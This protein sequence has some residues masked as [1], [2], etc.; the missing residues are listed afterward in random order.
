MTKVLK[1]MGLIIAILLEWF[2]ILTIMVVFAIRSSAFQTF[3]ARQLTNYLSTELNTKVEIGGVDIVLFK[4]VDLRNFYMEDRTK[5]PLLHLNHLFIELDQF[6]YNPNKLNIKHLRLN[7]GEIN[8][9]REQKNGNYNYAFIQHYIDANYRTK[10]SKQFTVYLNEFSLENIDL[11]YNDFRRESIVKG[12]DFNHLDIRNINLNAQNFNSDGKK[13]I[14]SI[15]DL[16]FNERSGFAL[17]HMV[18]ILIFTDKGLI[19]ENAKIQTKRSLILM[20]K[21]AIH[22]NSRE[23]F[24]S[25]NEHNVYDIEISPSKLNSSDVVFFAPALEGMDQTFFLSGRIHDKVH[26]LKISDLNLSFGENSYLH[27]QIQLPDFRQP[28]QKQLLKEQI[29]KAHLQLEDLQNLHLPAKYEAIEIPKSLQKAEFFDLKNVK[30]KG[31][32]SKFQLTIAE[33]QTK[34]GTLE[35]AP[36]VLAT[37]N[38]QIQIKG[39]ADTSF[40]ILKDFLLGEL[41]EI[42]EIGSLS[43]AVRCELVLGFDG[44][45]DLK[46]GN[47]LLKS[48]N[49]NN[50]SYSNISINDLQV[51]NEQLLS[52]VKVNDPHLQLSSVLQLNL[53]SIPSYQ[54]ELNLSRADLS[55]LHLSN[56]PNDHFSAQINLGLD[57]QNSKTLVGYASLKDYTYQVDEHQIN[58]ELAQIHIRKIDEITNL[59]ISSTIF[60]FSLEGIVDQTS[61]TNDLSQ[62]LAVIYPPLVQSGDF[63]HTD[64]G[65]KFNITARQTDDFFAIFFP[66]LKVSNGTVLSGSFNSKDELLKVDLSSAHIKFENLDL[67]QLKLN[68]T[69]HQN[70]AQGMFAI[71]EFI[72]ADSTSF[73]NLNFSHQGAKGVQDATLSWDPNTDDYSLIRWRTTMLSKNYISL[74]LQPSFYTINGVKWNVSNLSEITLSGDEIMVSDFLL[75]RGYQRIQL[76]GCLSE[77][78]RDQIRFDVLGLDLSEVSDLLGLPNSYNGKL[79]GW[80][81]ISTPFTNLRISAD[82][83]IEEFEIDGQAVGN[84]MLHSDWNDTR[85]SIAL[86]G[87]LQYRNERTFDFDGRYFVKEDILDLG[88]NFKRTDISFAN[89]YLDPQIVKD[90]KGKLDGRL[91]LSGSPSHPKLEGNLQLNNGGAQ[92]AILGVNYQLEGL[93]KVTEDAFFIDNAPLKDPE[94]NIAYLSS[95]VNHNNFNSWNYDIQLNFEDDINKID[96]ITNQLIPLDRF[97]V[98]NTKYKDGD[99]YYGKA[100]GRGVAN[101]FGTMNNTEITVDATSKKGT[102][103]IFPMYGMSEINEQD[104]IV[105][106]INR[107]ATKQIEQK[108]IDF[109]GLDLDLNFHI[110]P[111]ANMKL[112]FNDQT[113]DEII[114]K[115]SGEIN[116]KLDQYDQLSMNGPYV[117]SNGSRY[118]FALG[119]IKQTFDIEGGSKIEWTGDPYNADI[120]INTIAI[121]RASILELSP[122]LQDNSLVNQEIHCYLRLEE[123]LLQPKITFDI[124]APRTTQTGKALIDRVKSDPDELNRQF[125]SLLLVSKFQP[126]KGSLSAGGS[127]ALDLLESQIN[128]AL[129][130]LSENYKLN[131]DYGSDALAGESSVELG[132]AKGFLDDKL[133]ITGSFG[134]ENRTAPNNGS[135]SFTNTMIGDVNVEYK[136]QDNF[137]I[138]AF[139]QS[140]SNSVNE[141]QGP[142]TQGFGIS[143]FEEFQRFSDLSFIKQF[144]QLLKFGRKKTGL[145]PLKKH[146]QPVTLPQDEKSTSSQPRRN[147]STRS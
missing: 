102:E 101:I 30:L 121:K 69:I 85:Q 137:S 10:S 81:T 108:G 131:L 72:V 91:K 86:D 17:E 99:V 54:L 22:S 39:V 14:C 58:G 77:N 126:L 50:Y 49:V 128:A 138:R 79:S 141:N 31:N 143:Y 64:A 84:I 32:P 115:G 129:G 124:L 41:V 71:N 11:K 75:S 53:G 76:D 113:G 56:I 15:K 55:Q 112:I 88:L 43:G 95:A 25:F 48:L 35:L 78:K 96:P 4:H 116:V 142:F 44:K 19:L 40:L 90:I 52:K 130:K 46:N 9:S 65:F 92:I 147:R 89:A 51:R 57:G 132:V 93:I 68:E 8:I 100:Y 104:N 33:A 26:A 37:E 123:S 28:T 74:A 23:D 6:L 63:L 62:H 87:T 20:P 24:L 127:A 1:I 106:F 145:P 42:P 38:K 13:I 107:N 117:I 146:R 66:D 134:V 61:L 21:M 2:L 118:N 29:T 136:I 18:S 70:T 3:L 45:Y 125:F 140:N 120:N 73:H 67:R 83:N 109:T 135:Q 122:E 47:G 103:I 16:N 7:G 12:I 34:L 133:V 97:M 119:S 36:V 94:G 5:Q 80:G 98:L 114:A 27:A 105:Q 144:K 59:N 111:E 139:N 60:D 82:A 110:T